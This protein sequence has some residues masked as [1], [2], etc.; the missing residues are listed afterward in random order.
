[1]AVALAGL[2]V[3]RVTTLLVGVSSE[4]LLHIL[5]FLLGFFHLATLLL[6]HGAANFLGRAL[7][8]R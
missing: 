8:I 2:L 4:L 3:N 5:A 6:R 7:H 1:M